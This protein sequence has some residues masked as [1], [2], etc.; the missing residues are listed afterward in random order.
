MQ[1]PG[2]EREDVLVPCSKFQ[3][4]VAA[5]VLT[6]DLMHVKR[7]SPTMFCHASNM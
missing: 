3:G 6:I 2:E 1:W 4:P 7:W 5:S